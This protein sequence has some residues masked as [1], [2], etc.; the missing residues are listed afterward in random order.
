MAPQL[1]PNVNFALTFKVFSLVWQK[2][3]AVFVPGDEP[4]TDCRSETGGRT[5]LPRISH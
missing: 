3:F 4:D 2:R 1:V 5:T